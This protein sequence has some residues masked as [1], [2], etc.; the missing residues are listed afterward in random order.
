MKGIITRLNDELVVKH[1]K[2]PTF[3]RKVEY[4]Y[5]PLDLEDFFKNNLKEGSEV[6]FY[7]FDKSESINSES[8]VV[9]RLD[10]KNLFLKI[11][12]SY[13]DELIKE[14]EE[15]K[16]I[17]GDAMCDEMKYNEMRS[18]IDLLYFLK[19]KFL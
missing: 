16:D 13:I 11:P 5:Y 1:I 6:E 17:F 12:L 4:V 8:G 14:Y 9:A 10:S 15:E 7:L 19:E 18:K 2:M 3:G